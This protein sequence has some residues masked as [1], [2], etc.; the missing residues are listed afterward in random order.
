MLFFK[1]SNA[2]VEDILTVRTDGFDCV[3]SSLLTAT[4]Y[5]KFFVLE[6]EIITAAVVLTLILFNTFIL[7]FHLICLYIYIY[8]YI[9]N[10]V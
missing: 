3:L 6:L 9:G 1:T 7:I 2:G 10:L 5:L 8:I 4:Y